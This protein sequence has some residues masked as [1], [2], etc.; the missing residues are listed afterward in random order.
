MR[1]VLSGAQWFT[2]ALLLACGG[3]VAGWLG[4]RRHWPAPLR[5][6]TLVVLVLAETALL[7]WTMAWRGI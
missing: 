5:L 2:V 1:N 4:S 6:V 7:L 3:A